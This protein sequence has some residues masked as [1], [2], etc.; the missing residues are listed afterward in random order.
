MVSFTDWWVLTLLQINLLHFVPVIQDSRLQG[1]IIGKFYP[2]SRYLFT[3]WGLN[4]QFIFRHRTV[5]KNSPLPKYLRSAENPIH[6][7][8]SNGKWV[9]KPLKR[10]TCQLMW[11]RELVVV[12]IHPLRT[13]MRF[14]WEISANKIA[15]FKSAAEEAANG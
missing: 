10:T 14:Q 3:D 6:K 9:I 7:K 4:L 11:A 15:G 13:Q 8:W 2:Y 12:T 1:K 5:R